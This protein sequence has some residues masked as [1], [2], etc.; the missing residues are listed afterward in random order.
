MLD[1]RR[2]KVAKE[3]TKIYPGR[4]AVICDMLSTDNSTYEATIGKAEVE[5][6]LYMKCNLP[7][8]V[9]ISKLLELVG[10]YGEEKYEEAMDECAMRD[11][12]ADL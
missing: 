7:K 8:G 12:G 3:D 2:L 6:A 11:A 1:P 9:N 10:N 5:L 4:K